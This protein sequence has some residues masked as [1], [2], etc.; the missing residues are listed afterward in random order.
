MIFGRGVGEV[1][2]RRGPCR[3]MKGRVAYAGVT[4]VLLLF[5]PAARR[6]PARRRALL[7]TRDPSPALKHQSHDPATPNGAGTPAPL[8]GSDAGAGQTPV[9]LPRQFTTLKSLF[10]LRVTPGVKV[11]ANRGTV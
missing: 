11:I 10:G 8:L 1:G 5:V 3:A 4:R 6:P 7:P 2:L 9:K